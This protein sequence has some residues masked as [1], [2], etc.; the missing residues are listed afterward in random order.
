VERILK[1]ADRDHGLSPAGARLLFELLEG[2]QRGIAIEDVH[3]SPELAHE[4]IRELRQRRL[5]RVEQ[6]ALVALVG[7]VRS[8]LWGWEREG[9]SAMGWD[10]YME[11]M[12]AGD[13]SG[14]TRA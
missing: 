5:I 12:P 7:G 2:P 14:V 10:E 11:A 13:R 1:R 9:M 3:M 8:N 6:Q 4:A